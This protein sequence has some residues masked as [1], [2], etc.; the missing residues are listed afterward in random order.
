MRSRNSLLHASFIFAELLARPGTEWVLPQMFVR[1][2][3][4][5]IKHSTYKEALSRSL[6]NDV[7]F[8]KM[9]KN[10]GKIMQLI[11]A[12]ISFSLFGQKSMGV[13][14]NPGKG[15]MTYLRERET[16]LLSRSIEQNGVLVSET[17]RMPR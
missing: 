13:I 14:S 15:S 12:S 10:D 11:S 8:R 4:R 16:P 7:Y 2:W 6:K 17:G 1:T 3:N 5:E 9:R